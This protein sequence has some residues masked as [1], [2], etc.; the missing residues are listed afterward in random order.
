[1]DIARSS[2]NALLNVNIDKKFI[3]PGVNGE[4]GCPV[5]N[6]LFQCLYTLTYFYRKWLNEDGS[7]CINLI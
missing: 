4:K 5:Y 2:H 6:T 3:L 7:G 1:M